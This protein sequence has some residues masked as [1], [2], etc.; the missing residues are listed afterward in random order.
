[1]KTADQIARL[2]GVSPQAIREWCKKNGVRKGAKGRFLIDESTEALIFKHYGVELSQVAQDT[3][4]A[5]ASQNKQIDALID[6]LRGELEARNEQLKEKDRQIERL[7][8]A[9]DQQQKLQLISETK[10]LAPPAEDPA[11]DPT[12]EEPKKELTKEEERVIYKRAWATMPQSPGFLA[13][14]KAI[15]EW[16]DAQDEAIAKMTEEERRI[17]LKFGFKKGF[18]YLWEK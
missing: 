2:C 5:D 8:T 3:Q 18:R 9:L 13:S 15:A 16:E 17:L 10:Q 4:Q 7:Q 11:E 6:A 1:M 12:P 14:P